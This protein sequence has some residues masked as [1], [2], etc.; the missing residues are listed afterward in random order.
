MRPLA[1]AACAILRGMSRDG[2]YVFQAPGGDMPMG[3]FPRLWA[4]VVHRISGLPEDV[5]PH[6]HLE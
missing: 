1:E 6:G 5:T 3:G 2:T 4:R